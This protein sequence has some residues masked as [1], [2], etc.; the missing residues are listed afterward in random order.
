MKNFLSLIVL[1][2][3]GY[4]TFAQPSPPRMDKGNVKIQGSVVDSVSSQPIEFANVALLDAATQKPVDG[5]MCDDKGKFV[6]HK[7]GEGTYDLVIT[8]LGYKTQAI[9]NIRVTEDTNEVNLGTIKLGMSVQVLKEV[10]VEGQRALIEERVDRTVY[11]AEND[12]TTRGGD[13]T[14]VLKRVPMLSVDLDGNVMLRGSSNIKVLI[15]N[16]PSTI[17]ASSIADALKQIPADQIKTVEVI[18]S[19]SAKYD[20]EGTGGIINIITK[21]NTLQGATLSVDAGVGLRGSNLGLN[22]NYRTKKMGFSLGGF[23]RSNYNVNGS[24]ENSQITRDGE[25]SE[26]LSLQTADTRTQGLF[27]NYTLGWD[28]DIDKKNSLAASVRFGARN[29]KNFQDDLF[30]ESFTNNDPTGTLLQDVVTKDNSNNVD[31]NLTYTRTFEKPQKEFSFLAMYS[32]NNRDNDFE[33]LTKEQDGIAAANGVLNKNNSYNQEITLQADYQIPI[34]TNQLVE[35]GGK[36]IVRKAFSDYTY[37]A[38]EDGDG[39]YDVQTSTDLT[40]NLNYDQNVMGGYLSYTYTTTSGYSFKAGS[41]YEYTT[42]NAYTRTDNDINIPSYGIVVPSVNVSKKLKN[43]NMVKASFNRRIQRPSIQYLNPNRQSSNILNQTEGN[44]ELEPEYTNNYEVGYSTY[45]KGTSLNFSGFWRNTNNSIQSLR[46]TITTSQGPGILTTYENIGKENAYGLSVFA[47]VNAGKLSLNGGTDIYYT[48]LTNNNPLPQYNASNKGWVASYR[49]FGSYDLT[50]GWGFQFFGFYRGRQVQLQGYQTGFGIYSL[51][52]KKDINDKKGSIG[53]GAENFFTPSFKIRSAVSSTLYE[54][55]SLNVM[56]N[57][58]FRITFSY[59][60]GKM[61]VDARPRKRKSINNDDLKED[62]GGQ[63]SN[64][65]QSGGGQGG[66]QSGSRQFG[67]GGTPTPQRSTASPTATPQAQAPSPTTPT[68]SA[69]TASVQAEGTWIYTV[70]SP[71]G[72]E[73]TLV[74]KK[75]GDNYTGTI[76]NKRFNKEIPLSSVSL[77]GHEL[78]FSYDVS[79]G[80]NTM[81]IQVK[82]I[83]AADTFSGNMAVGQFGTFPINATRNP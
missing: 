43:G 23:G 72:G 15:N 63:D 61:S 28:Y 24:F 65:M 68:D 19:P 76:T 2:F 35:F 69:T 47:N 5:A 58:S 49:F 46:D 38:D 27:G 45:I 53:F 20:A 54:T 39:Q 25:G 62:G 75:E 33:R 12:M 56:H 55:N 79:F 80:G 8:F 81:N 73:G 52:I 57:M 34:G 30:T 7:V 29:H 83:I 32:R 82:A 44:P 74:I 13:A 40:N 17:M 18:T 9:R 42:I 4:H 21:K 48:T 78:S 51:G 67:G 31:V 16:K 37:Y 11:N 14:D 3:L 36:D 71:Q 77:N 50:K 41:R 10:T 64:N 6:L 1:S 59:R 60:L 70:E 22:G 26:S 66:G